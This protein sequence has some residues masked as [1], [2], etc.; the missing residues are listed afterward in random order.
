LRFPL[1][2][3]W[4]EQVSAPWQRQVAPAMER[5]VRSEAAAM[6][7]TIAALLAD[8]LEPAMRQSGR[9]RAGP[10]VAESLASE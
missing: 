2:G 6:Q 7:V 3:R 4:D 9:W 5:I 1:A 8:T 10:R